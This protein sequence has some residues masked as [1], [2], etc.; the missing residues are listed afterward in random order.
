MIEQKLSSSSN[1]LQILNNSALMSL[2]SLSTKPQTLQD[3]PKI[4]YKYMPKSPDTRNLTPFTG[5]KSFSY[6]Y[7]L[8]MHDMKVKEPSPPSLIKIL[9]PDMHPKRKMVGKKLELV[10]KT[11]ISTNKAA[12]KNKFSLPQTQVSNEYLKKLANVKSKYFCFTNEK[13]KAENKPLR[14]KLVRIPQDK[15]S[16]DTTLRQKSAQRDE[17]SVIDIV[18][19]EKKTF[20]KNKSIG[21][22]AW[23]QDI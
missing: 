20:F 14:K 9:K 3:T 12:P 6:L 1:C 23:E 13:I 18:S 5:N 11:V 2:P 15:I 16:L 8:T 10:G 7:S 4:K 17:G 19:K 21:L 22:T